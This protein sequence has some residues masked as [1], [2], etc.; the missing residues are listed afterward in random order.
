MAIGTPVHVT[1]Q[2]GS[3]ALLTS[4]GLGINPPALDC[5]LVCVSRYSSAAAPGIP[6][7][8]GGT[9]VSWV[10]KFTVLLDPGSGDRMRLSLWAAQVPDPAPAT[11]FVTCTNPDSGARTAFHVVRIPG[12]SAAGITNFAQDDDG[13]G[14]PAATLPVSIGPASISFAFAGWPG[15]AAVD[16]PASGFTEL[17]EFIQADQVSQ[18]SYHLTPQNTATWTTSNNA[19]S[20]GAIVEIPPLGRTRMSAVWF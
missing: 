10:Q 6:V 16:P 8:S 19:N 9:G 17:N 1:R 18:T 13:N 15:T 4:P 20:L 12:A 5:L 2:G 7:I 3:G 14:D 11:F